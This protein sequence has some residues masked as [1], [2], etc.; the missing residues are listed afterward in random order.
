MAAAL[1][2]VQA[3]QIRINTHKRNNKKHRSNSTKH[4]K[5]KYTYCQ[6]TQTLQ[7]KLKQPQYKINAKLNSHNT[8][9]YNTIFGVRQIYLQRK[10]R[11]SRLDTTVSDTPYLDRML[12]DNKNRN[13][14]YSNVSNPG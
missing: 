6:N 10:C 5:Y 7:N 13:F 1:T 11:Q 3:K 14:R 12:R 8:I 4:S 9:Q 2:L